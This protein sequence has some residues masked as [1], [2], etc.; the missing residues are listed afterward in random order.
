VPAKFR[1]GICTPVSTEIRQTASWQGARS[2]DAQK[3]GPPHKPVY[4]RS[5]TSVAGH[6]AE[7]FGVAAIPSGNR[8]TYTMPLRQVA[9]VL[10]SHTCRR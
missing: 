10:V 9:C 1:F 4:A 8:V 3:S 6:A 7:V 5:R 2:I